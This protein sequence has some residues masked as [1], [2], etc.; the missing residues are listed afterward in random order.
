MQND[1]FIKERA[2]LRSILMEIRE[3]TGCTL[4]DA[5][6]AFYIT[7][8]DKLE[9]IRILREHPERFSSMGAESI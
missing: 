6:K 9:A 5:K 1:H 2:M 7:D 8:G 4:I 3:K